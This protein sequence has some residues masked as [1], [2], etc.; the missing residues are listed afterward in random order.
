MLLT[1]VAHDSVNFQACHAIACIKIHQIYHVIF[2]TKG[3]FC[4]KLFKPKTTEE[5]CLLAL[6][7]DAKCEGKLT[8]DFKNDMKN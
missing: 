8:C 7:I 5:L 2:G 6:N 4:F 3:Q 1:K